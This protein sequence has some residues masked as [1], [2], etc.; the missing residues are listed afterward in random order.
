MLRN[1]L[2]T[3]PIDLSAEEYLRTFS[4]Q[5]N[6]PARENVERHSNEAMKSFLVCLLVQY[7]QLHEITLESK[8]DTLNFFSLK[9][10]LNTILKYECH[11]DVLIHFLCKMPFPLPSGSSPSFQL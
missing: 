6:K 5:S 4:N 3:T 1:S 9:S 10:V 7:F 11:F 2:C 8:T